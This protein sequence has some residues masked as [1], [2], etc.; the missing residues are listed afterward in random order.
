MGGKSRRPSEPAPPSSALSPAVPPIPTG[1]VGSSERAPHPIA[2]A[3]KEIGS[4]Q[5]G[6]L[7]RNDLSNDISTSND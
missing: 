1:L 7:R 4:T 5:T 2:T 3:A 6:N